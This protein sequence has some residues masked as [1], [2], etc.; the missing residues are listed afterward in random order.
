MVFNL[1]EVGDAFEEYELSLMDTVEHLKSELNTIRAGR[2]NPQ[3]LNKITVDYYGALTPLN[4]MAN[5]TVP[6]ARLLQISLWDSSMI[7]AVVKAITASDI[8]I[9]PTDDGKVI[10]L[11]FPQLTEERRRDLGKQVKK[12]GEDY[13]VTLRNARRDIMDKLK[14]FN[15]NKQIT[16]DEVAT[17]E[18]EVQKIL[19]KNI[20]S[21]DT[22]IKEKENE[23]LEV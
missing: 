2:A 11:V 13:K 18:K 15:K 20:A 6:E 21:V 10:R 22:L 7:K 4:Q 12:V 3:I 23:I 16:D 1:P 8:G 9:T 5:I 19:D 17:Y 14:A